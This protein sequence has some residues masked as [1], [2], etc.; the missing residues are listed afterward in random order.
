MTCKEVM[1]RRCMAVTG[2]LWLAEVKWGVFDG[3][4]LWGARGAWQRC[5]FVEGMVFGGCG[6]VVSG[7]I[8]MRRS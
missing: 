5:A 1:A 6:D 3:V 2:W 8:W 4:G 7:G